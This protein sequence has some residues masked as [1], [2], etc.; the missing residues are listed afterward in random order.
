M[1]FAAF[2]LY[3]MIFISLVRAIKFSLQDIYRNIWLSIT[4]IIILLLAL[5]SINML[6]TVSLISNA[7]IEAVKEKI[8]IDLYLKNDAEEKKIMALKAEISN[9]SQ[10]KEIKYIS[11]AE[12][13]KT[14]KDEHRNDPEVLEALRA[15][16][17]NPLS[18]SLIIKTKGM[19]EY[20]ELISILN[21][22]DNEIIESRN[23][24]D[25]KALL[26]KINNIT[27]KVKEAGLTV[28]LIFILIT[29]L[30]VFN[31]IRVTIY[32][33][34][35][36]IKIMRLVGASIWFIRL[37]YFVSSAIYTLIGTILIIILFY[38]FLSLLQPYLETFFVGYNIN[39]IS[40]YN[41]NFIKIFGIEFLGTALINIL[42]SFIAVRKYSKV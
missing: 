17:K 20:E 13:L 42:A 34:R 24:D 2:A 35:R 6:L 4:T 28:S 16:G 18:P 29:V 41:N 31:A 27:Q 25:H 15:L 26:A 8:D 19:E 40:Y 1:Q 39:I 30:V 36:E 9:L 38:S 7:A 21:N 33:H 11:K 12:A 5:F 3:S 32:T 14:F 23:F 37:P 22:I 10:V